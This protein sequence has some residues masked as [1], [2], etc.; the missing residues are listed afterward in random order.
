MTHVKRSRYL[1][2]L[3]CIFSASN[4]NVTFVRCITVHAEIDFSF[5]IHQ[6]YKS[7]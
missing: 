5:P 7:C 4:E 2:Y 1:K 3:F 6:K